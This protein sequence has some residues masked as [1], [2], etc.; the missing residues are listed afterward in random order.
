MTVGDTELITLQPSAL[1]VDVGTISAAIVSSA[2]V[3]NRARNRPG[4]VLDTAS[5]F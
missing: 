1:A 4:F 5:S 3:P 2:A